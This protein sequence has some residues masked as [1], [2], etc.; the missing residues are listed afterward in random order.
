MIS[1]Y[2]RVHYSIVS[3]IAKLEDDPSLVAALCASLGGSIFS[4]LVFTCK[5]HTKIQVTFLFATS[6]ALRS[7]VIGPFHYG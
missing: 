6:I 4:Q 5:T 2:H 3:D 7:I 1:N